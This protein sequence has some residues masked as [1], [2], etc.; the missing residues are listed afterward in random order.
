MYIF[1]FGFVKWLFVCQLWTYY[2]F[3]FNA[4]QVTVQIEQ[5]H[6][7]TLNFFNNNI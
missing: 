6:Q 1:I 5:Q 2:S 3:D 4:G 7:V